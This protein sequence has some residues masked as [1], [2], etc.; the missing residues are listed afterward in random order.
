MATVDGYPGTPVIHSVSIPPEE[1][2][3]EH[4]GVRIDLPNA[5]PVGAYQ[6]LALELSTVADPTTGDNCY[7]GWNGENP[8]TYRGGQA[9]ASRDGGRTWLP[10]RKDLETISKLVAKI[11]VVRKDDIALRVTP[12]LTFPHQGGRDF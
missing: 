12:I 1:V 5:W 6:T 8:G 10:D 11:T 2:D 7:Y 9:F 4:S 3:L